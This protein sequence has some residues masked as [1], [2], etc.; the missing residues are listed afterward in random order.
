MRTDTPTERANRRRLALLVLLHHHPRRYSE[1]IAALDR[2]TLFSYDRA[3]DAAVIARQQHYQF[4]NDIQALR[5]LSC[6]ICCDRRT[7]CY[8]WENSPFG[9]SLNQ[10]QLATFVLLL[11]TFN[12]TTILHAR[13]IQALL[14]FLVERLPVEQQKVI[15]NQRAAFSI[16]LHETTDYRDADPLTIKPIEQAIA[17]KQQLR[18]TYCSPRT[19]Q[20][21]RHAI[22][23]EPLVFEHGHVYLYGWSLDREK[24]LQF[25]LDYIVPGSAE[26]LHNTIARSRP[27]PI[28]Y[29]LKY[30]LSPTIARNSVSQHFPGQQVETHPDGSATVTA[31]ITDLFEA[32]RTLLG[33]GENC[34]VLE[35]PALVQQLRAVALDF[36][37]YL[38]PDE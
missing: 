1:L 24:R 33:Y 35:P 37:K 19:G 27:A 14:S 6:D 29:T 2:D 26:V 28:S 18:F 4:R 5:L 15:A 36:Q 22:E 12:E 9:L 23:P 11:N 30:Q 17:R 32:R 21:R 20:E 7:G 3:S 8:S 31:Q 13:D 38:T 10:E 34:T 25:R 16:D